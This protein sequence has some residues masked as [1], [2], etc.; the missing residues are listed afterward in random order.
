MKIERLFENVPI[1]N[2]YEK[3]KKIEIE[4]IET[5]SK[6]HSKNSLFFCLKGT[7]TDGHDFAQ[8]AIKNGAKVLVVERLLNLQ[9]PQIL[10]ENARKTLALVCANFFN[11]PQKNLKLIG[12]T[13]T[14][15]KTSTTL[16]LQ[17]IFLTAKQSVGVIGT[18]GYFINQNHFE[19]DMTTPDPYKLFEILSQMKKAGVKYVFME[20]SAH[21][22]YFNKIEGLNFE[23]GVL[24]NI[25][26]DH[27][28]FFNNMEN[29]SKTKLDF[30]NSKA[31]KLALV[32]ADD[33][34]YFLVKRDLCISYGI[35][36]PADNF[37]VNI[38]LKLGKTSFV[39]NILDNIIKVKTNLTGMFNVYN[40]LVACSV[41]LILGI[42]QIYIKKALKQLEAI[43]GRFNIF[44]T[45]KGEVIV[46]FA[47]TPDGLEN[48]LKTIR[49]ISGKNI[50]CVFGCNG[51]RDAL[52][53][54]LMGKIAEE[55]C[56]KVILTSDNPRFENAEIIFE[57]ILSDVK[58]KAKFEREQDR[59]LAIKKGIKLLKKNKKSVLVICGKG[60]EEYQDINGIK[61]PYNELEVVEN[62]LLEEKLIVKEF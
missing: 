47:H 45:K 6:N 25:T 16:I 4:T 12:I 61:V 3:F 14:N 22:I 53:R 48:V 41:S 9:V 20:V 50:I 49:Q 2:T 13:G 31:V 27:L 17:K 40:V 26:Q 28:E 36:N 59:I 44:K 11:N 43:K 55:Y 56:S 46:D 32:N 29:Y 37:A 24:T 5:N 8:E 34:S 54:P 10:V 7:N 23:I 30:I 51:N 1:I 58:H 42:K 18:L 33:K 57:N 62:C 52:K 21:A 35:E 38:D 19:C 39:L 60:G 15:G